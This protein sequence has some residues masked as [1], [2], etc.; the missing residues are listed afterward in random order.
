M[1]A[2]YGSSGNNDDAFNSSD[3]LIEMDQ[4]IRALTLRA[5][6]AGNDEDFDTAFLT[7]ESA[8]WLTQSLGKRCLEATTL[9][10]LGLLYTMQG[11]WD[12]AMLTFDRAMGMAIE[13]CPANSP[14]L[15]TLT[16]NIACLFDPK[17]TTPVDPHID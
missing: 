2:E 8:L 10:N 6:A 14:F 7:M 5:M 4:M 3:Y 1:A 11:E 9:N 16:Q 15:S 17:I 12:R 13:S